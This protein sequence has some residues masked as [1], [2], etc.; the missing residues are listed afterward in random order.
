MKILNVLV[1]L[2]LAGI[3]FTSCQKEL[4]FE[5]I[6]SVG[7]LK[8][9]T[10]FNCLPSTVYGE[11]ITDSTLTS[12]NYI[13]VQVNI[14]A[15]GN[16]LIQSDTINGYSFSGTGNL[17]TAG[18]N[19][20]KLYGYGKPVLPGLN[21]F[22]IRF[23]TSTCVID[24]NVEVPGGPA[25]FAL[26]GA[27]GT[28]TGAVLN[29]T[30]ME[31]FPTSVSNTAVV[32]VD[33]TT[34]GNYAISTT[35]VNGI[36]FTGTG[37]FTTLGPQTVSLTASGTPSAAGPFNFAVSGGGGSGCAFSVTFD[38]PAPPAAFT[39]GGAP[40]NCTGVLLSGNYAAGTAMNANNNI[41][42]NVTV[43]SAG[44]YSI[45][46][47]SQDGISFSGSGLLTL[48]STQITLTASGTPAA[49]GTFN[50]DVSTGGSI[51][52]FSV[53]VTAPITD[54]ITCDIDGVAATFNVNTSAILDNAS[55]P[56][57]L[58]FFGFKNATSGS[59]FYFNIQKVD[60]AD[61]TNGTYT[62]NQLATFTYLG[63]TYTDDAGV[64]FGAYTDLTGGTQNPAFT[65]NVTSLTATRVVG[66]FSGPVKDNNGAGPGI[67]QIT[68]GQFDLPL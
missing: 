23:D 44:S 9:D 55:V 30:Y 56:S 52:T 14:A 59:Q 18:L 64:D 68:N 12:A 58:T 46:T 16:Y 22:I 39:L 7:T 36:T 19:T 45:T 28:C 57:D 49:G 62:V 54:F 25:S 35:S 17:G 53:I 61:I 63:V 10:A 27:G 65:V 4:D 34:I 41:T 50:Y 11:Y 29:G 43:T 31:A 33:V 1:L 38:A 51:C 48:T 42:L 2:M 20:V 66:T 15:T 47:I 67:K 8:S 6:D 60:G 32:A 21:Q 24:V 13:E 40:G 37:A 5:N 26:A 3:L